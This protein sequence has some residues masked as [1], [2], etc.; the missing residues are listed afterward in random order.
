MVRRSSYFDEEITAYDRALPKYFVAAFLAVLV[1]ALHAVVKNIPPVHAWLA[2]AGHGGHLVRDIA[3]THLM[4]V[5]GGTVGATA[6]TWYVLPRVLRRPLATPRLAGFSFWATVLGAGGFYLT[7]VMVGIHAGRLAHAGVSW[8]D[9]EAGLGAWKAVPIALSATV[10]GIG[11]WTFVLVVVLTAWKGRHITEAQPDRHLSWFFVVGALALFVG[12]VQGVIQVMPAQEDWLHAAAPAGEYID[13]IAHAHVN[14]VTGL[15]T[16]VFGAVFWWTRNAARAPTE[17]STERRVFWVLVPGSV[18]FY[19]TFMVLGFREGA[20]IVDGG[21]SFEQAV[22]HMGWRHHLPLALGGGLTFVGL[23]AGLAVVL[24]RALRGRIAA[25]VR[26]LLV[27]AV[28]ALGIGVTQGLIQLTPSVKGF[29]EDAGPYGDSL[30]NAHAQLN[31][32][33]GILLAT[34]AL[35]L[36][37]SPVMF[38]AAVPPSR[39]ETF[40]TWAIPGVFVTYA[41]AVLTALTSGRAV[42][43]G[44]LPAQDVWAAVIGPSGLVAGATAFAVGF[45]AVAMWA[46]GANAGARAAAWDRLKASTHAYSPA[47]EWMDRARWYWFVAIEVVAAASGFPGLGWI[48][49][50]RAV[51]GLPLAL[52]GP[53]MAWAVIPVIMTGEGPFSLGQRGPALEVLWIAT[54]T[55]VSASALAIHLLRSRGHARQPDLDPEVVS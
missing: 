49:A 38:G 1:A 3:N 11:Y 8:E 27:A 37:R 48:F 47:P 10:M 25:P 7:N 36:D 41:F 13:P 52:V 22:A 29:I 35:A 54:T 30:A 32:M 46:W 55:L 18:L 45:G 43:D 50:G 31:M 51:V 6:L 26:P 12:T 4:I 14:L 17:R 20:L 28:V 33:G 9:A 34:A 24:G 39:V 23:V 21:L 44:R 42:L 15:L 53:A 19:V 5:L 2:D 40:R 16:T